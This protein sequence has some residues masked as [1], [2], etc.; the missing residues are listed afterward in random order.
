VF[1]FFLLLQLIKNVYKQDA[2][3]Y[4][5][6]AFEKAVSRVLRDIKVVRRY[7][8]SVI[9]AG[10][11]EIPELLT[12]SKKYGKLGMSSPVLCFLLVTYVVCP[13]RN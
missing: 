4:R 13:K 6:P 10:S 9:E 2:V 7:V 1:L 11:I 12:T 3:L 8:F 5:I